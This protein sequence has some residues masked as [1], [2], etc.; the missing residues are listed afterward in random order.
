MNTEFLHILLDGAA[1][2]VFGYFADSVRR[3]V[4]SIEELNLKVAVVINQLSDHDRRIVN[5]EE[6]VK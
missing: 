2:A 4:T 6:K 1:I 3:V 5:I